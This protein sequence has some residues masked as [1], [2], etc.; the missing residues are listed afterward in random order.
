MKS[1]APGA[2]SDRA[3]CPEH[4]PV[5]L[6]ARSCR[7][8]LEP[9]PC[10][11]RRSLFHPALLVETASGCTRTQSFPSKYNNIAELH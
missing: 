11:V 2:L 1:S 4:P 6:S 7:R 5:S 9:P 3:I 10:H 8:C